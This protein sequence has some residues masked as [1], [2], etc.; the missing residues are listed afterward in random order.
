M[1]K[2]GLL[3]AL[4]GNVSVISSYPSCKDSNSRFKTVSWNLPDIVRISSPKKTFAKRSTFG[5]KGIEGV[6]EDEIGKP[7]IYLI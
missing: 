4:K 3:L 6:M 5:L 2:K 7:V 1:A